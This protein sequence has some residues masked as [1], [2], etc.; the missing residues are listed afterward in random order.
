MSKFILKFIVAATI[1][2]G[3]FL[4]VSGGSNVYAATNNCPG[5]PDAPAYNN[6][7]SHVG[8]GVGAMAALEVHA[9]DGSNPS[10]Q[11]NVH[12]T[13][14]S[15]LDGTH[16]RQIFQWDTSTHTY[17]KDPSKRY[18]SRQFSTGENILGDGGFQC[19]GWSVIGPGD[20]ITHQDGNG[21]VLD[22]GSGDLHTKYRISSVENPGG[23]RGT[24]SLYFQ[25]RLKSSDVNN[26]S[27]GILQFPVNNGET[28]QLT[29]VWHPL[30]W[31]TSPNS[32]V[33]ND[34]TGEGPQANVTATT[35]QH[36]TF[37][38]TITTSGDPSSYSWTV[39][40]KYPSDSTWTNVPGKHGNGSGTTTVHVGLT[41]PGGAKKDQLFCRKYHLSMDKEVVRIRA[42]AMKRV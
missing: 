6:W 5:A 18:S 12:Y 33:K 22:C 29:L 38:H 32:V 36:T 25:G 14:N 37:T 30:T 24:W 3:A 2:T 20:S 42:S 40:E 41:I 16:D 39:E 31:N 23:Q 34:N 17:S 28:V 35:G 26:S 8:D 19:N 7:G 27:P 4:F 10:S 11:L 15:Y 21:Y 1:M 9:Y 13:I